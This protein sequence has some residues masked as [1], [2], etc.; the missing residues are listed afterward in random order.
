MRLSDLENLEED[1]EQVKALS[2]LLNRSLND[3]LDYCKRND[4]EPYSD[5]N[6]GKTALK[7]KI[8]LLRQE[9]M[10]LSLDLGKI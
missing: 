4:N 9:L 8:M 10:R 5:R 1:I 3:W 2:N 7:R 6:I